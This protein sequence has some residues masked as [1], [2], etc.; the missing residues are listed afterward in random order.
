MKNKL[1]VHKAFSTTELCRASRLLVLLTIAASAG[2]QAYEADTHGLLTGIAANNS[3]VGKS[4]AFFTDMGMLSPLTQFDYA[5]GHFGT[6]TAIDLMSWGAVYEDSLFD[7][8]AL[9]HFYDPQNNRGLRVPGLVPTPDGHGVLATV[10]GGGGIASIDWAIEASGAAVADPNYNVLP[11]PNH[12]FTYRQAAIDFYN[13]LASGYDFNRKTAEAHMFQALGHVVH[14]IQDMGQPQ[15]TRNEPHLHDTI[16]GIG[17]EFPVGIAAYEKYTQARN[18]QLSTIIASNAYYAAA[19]H[20]PNLPTASSYFVT[21]AGRYVGMSEFT[22]Q[23]FLTISTEMNYSPQSGALTPN[24]AFP[25]PSTGNIQTFTTPVTVAGGS[26]QLANKYLVTTV[27]DGYSGIPTQIKAAKLNLLY[28]LG[29]TQPA[30]TYFTPDDTVFNDWNSVLIPRAASFSQG[31]IDHFFRGRIFV[32]LSS[33]GRKATITNMGADAINGKVTLLNEAASNHFRS[34]VGWQNVSLASAGSAVVSVVSTLTPGSLVI[35]AFR[36]QI[37]IEGDPTTQSTYYQVAGAK[38]TAP[39]P[40]PPAPAPAPAPSPSPAPAPA[41]ASCVRSTPIIWSGTVGTVDLGTSKGLV[42]I[43]IA[44]TGLPYNWTINE[45]GKQL[46]NLQGITGIH[47]Q[48]INY[49]GTPLSVGFFTQADWY[50]YPTGSHYEYSVTCPGSTTEV[51]SFQYK[52]VKFSVLGNVCG[53]TWSLTIDSGI[54]GGP[55]IYKLPAGPG[56]TITYTTSGPAGLCVLGAGGKYWGDLYI[57]KGD[58]NGNQQ[59]LTGL[60]TGPGYFDLPN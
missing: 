19:S 8:V 36:G 49:D 1:L 20:V 52:T 5:G 3:V 13:A 40:P 9:D 17:W 25:L 12:G 24:S 56:H 51:H 55:G 35:A 26:Y 16:L 46:V 53:A 57:D 47:Y 44:G 32:S 41:P 34:E 7:L 50:P 18:G 38:T 58:G 4:P 42:T 14:H 30:A 33:D 45:S 11:G 48:K 54:Y 60:Q 10:S 37:G 31:L 43:G 27:T 29:S 6:G 59:I 28:E 23:N 39:T 22:S 2:V 15:H 21:G